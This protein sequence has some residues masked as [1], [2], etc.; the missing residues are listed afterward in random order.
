MDTAGA[1]SQLVLYS[2][3]CLFA[4]GRRITEAGLDF[5]ERTV[6]RGGEMHLDE[7]AV[8]SMALDRVDVAGSS[9]AVQARIRSLRE[10]Y[11]IGLEAASR[12]IDGAVVYTAAAASQ[13]SHT[14][15]PIPTVKDSERSVAR[16]VT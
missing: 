7:R 6:L 5:I 10:R 11:G 16:S 2:F 8:L 15:Q 1:G 12:S 3:Q 4:R 9:P 13:N 14:Q